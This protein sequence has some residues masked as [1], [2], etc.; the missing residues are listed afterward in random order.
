MTT[1]YEKCILCAGS[2]K[3][4]AYSVSE[5]LHK[6]CLLCSGWATE[7]APTV[8]QALCINPVYCMRGVLHGQGVLKI[9][10][11]ACL[12]S[13]ESLH[14]AYLLCVRCGM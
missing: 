1:V 2:L 8:C 5:A 13:A 14:K 3:K 9:L 4:H 12:L 11:K 7:S 10:H 6:A